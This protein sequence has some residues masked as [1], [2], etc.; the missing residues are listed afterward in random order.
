MFDSTTGALNAPTFAKRRKV[1]A[2]FAAG[3]PIS[4]MDD[5]LILGTEHPVEVL[6]DYME[7]ASDDYIVGLYRPTMLERV[8]ADATREVVRVTE[9]DQ[10]LDHFPGLDVKR[11]LARHVNR[12]LAVAR[13]ACQCTTTHPDWC[14]Y[15]HGPHHWIRAVDAALDRSHIWSASED[16]WTRQPERSRLHHQK[17][18]DTRHRHLKGDP[19]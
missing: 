4:Q 6:E 18:R 7:E 9:S 19:K 14:D 15:E 17:P 3:L 8:L 16:V 1:A 11:V 12:V 13:R 10:V 5:F 2:N